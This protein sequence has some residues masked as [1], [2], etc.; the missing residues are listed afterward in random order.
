MI[1]MKHKILLITAL[2]CM[3]AQGAWADKWD[4]RTYKKPEYDLS[5][6]V[7]YINSAAELAYILYWWDSNV[8][9]FA[10]YPKYYTVNYKL[11][12]DLDMT[13]GNW[14]PLGS[15]AYTGEFDGNGHTIR[16]NIT[17][18]TDNYQGL[19]KEIGSDGKVKNLHVAGEI[20]CK[21]SRLVGGICGENN[22]KIQNCW[23]SANVSSEWTGAGYAKVG[24]ICG[25]NDGIVEFCCMT[26]DVT[27]Y[28]DN[29]GGI[30]GDNSGDIVR[31]CTFYGNLNIDTSKAN[32]D[33]YAGDKGTVEDCYDTYYDVHYDYASSSGQN[34]YAYAY[35]YPYP[36]DVR[37]NGYGSVRVSAGG[38]ND[39]SE[40]R[41]VGKEC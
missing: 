41:R 29:V 4:G 10:D 5:K 17:E 22:G 6:E 19:F 33:K 30:V 28:D 36:I 24:G 40:E 23:V 2:L 25:Q 1:Q 18:V 8:R 37:T 21:S 11:N 9:I 31:H 15:D 34:M 35:K 27:N 7:V 14:T 39:R 13:A 26:G 12:T 16:I 38:E 3:A 32:E 20:R